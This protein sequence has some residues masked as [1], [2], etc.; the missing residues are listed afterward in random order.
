MTQLDCL[1]SLCEYGQSIGGESCFPELVDAGPDGKPILAFTEGKHPVLVAMSTAKGGGDSFIPND[2]SLN[3][4]ISIITG[5]NM[6]GKSTI[7]RQCGLLA[8]LAQ[9]GCRVP[10]ESMILSPVD[11]VF[12]RMG[13]SDRIMEGASTFYV[14]L[15]ETANILKNATARSLVIVDELGRGTTTYDGRAIA[16]AVLHELAG[17]GCREVQAQKEN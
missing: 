2:V 3:D 11:R 16:K 5:A 10:A 17:R 9:L 14:E 12:S 13:A 7:M 4:K 1:L 6:G 15:S 8:I